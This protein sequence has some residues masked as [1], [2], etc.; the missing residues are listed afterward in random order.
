MLRLARCGE[1]LEW[2]RTRWGTWYSGIAKTNAHGLRNDVET[3][4]LG[5]TSEYTAKTTEANVGIE[6]GLLGPAEL[7]PPA[8]TSAWDKLGMYIQV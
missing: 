3:K 6:R 4:G 1:K 5:I 2:R 7:D 8:Q